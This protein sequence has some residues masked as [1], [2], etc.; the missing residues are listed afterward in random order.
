MT[1]TGQFELDQPLRGNGGSVAVGY[2]SSRVTPFS[3]ALS[4][5]QEVDVGFLK[6]FFYPFK[7]LDDVPKIHPLFFLLDSDLRPVGTMLIP[8]VQR[9]S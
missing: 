5:G 6:L 8:L 2:G 3:Y 7:K 1:P 9:G 4:Y